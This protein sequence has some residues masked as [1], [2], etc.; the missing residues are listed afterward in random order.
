M[1]C[2][3]RGVLA[4]STLW[5]VGVSAG[6]IL[7][8][9]L[10]SLAIQPSGPA[11]AAGG[12]AQIDR[13]SFEQGL[14]R[15]RRL[16]R[17]Q[18]WKL[19]RD[20]W[21]ELARAHSGAEYARPELRE[22][23]LELQRASFWTTAVTPALRTLLSG[24]LLDHDPS[25]GTLRIRYTLESMGDFGRV[26]GSTAYVHPAHF[27]GPWTI[28][29]SGTAAEIR[30]VTLLC[31][32]GDSGVG[33]KFGIREPQETTYYAHALFAYEKQVNRELDS[34]DPKPRASSATTVKAQV[35]VGGASVRAQYDGVDV[36]EAPHA[37]SDFGQVIVI[38]PD[39]YGSLT[40][41]GEVD[42][43]WIDGLMDRAV[44]DQRRAFDAQWKD[45][46][47]FAAWG[48]EAATESADLSLSALLS[49]VKF[50]LPV[51]KAQDERVVALAAKTRAGRAD[52]L[53][54]LLEI[55]PP[56]ESSLPAESITYLRFCASLALG[57][58]QAALEQLEQLSPRAGHEREAKILRAIL[59]GRGGR[60]AES[61]AELEVLAK[62]H[63]RLAPLHGHLVESLLR[64][65]LRPEARA[66]MGRARAAMPASAELAK[67]EKQLVKAEMGPTWKTVFEI[68]GR[69][70]TVRSEVSAALC[71]D[72]LRVLD[73]AMERCTFE[74]GPLPTDKRERGVVYLF[75]GKA[76]YGDYV[77][78][79]ADGS[80]ENTRGIYSLLLKQ[81]VA[82]NQP[83]AAQLWDTLRHECVHRYLDLCVGDVPRWFGEGLAETLAAS[84]QADEAW[85]PGSLRSGWIEQ[86]KGGPQSVP[87][88][89]AFAYQDESEFRA[90]I[91]RSYAFAWAWMHYLRFRNSETRAL[92]AALWAALRD[93][94]DHSVAM[95]RALRGRNVEAL[96]RDFRAFFEELRRD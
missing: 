96:D 69:H 39:S 44:V 55:E 12:S 49:A 64:Q 47:E 63:P 38:A 50:E 10:S 52:A 35:S 92:F 59:L 67:L 31:S 77:A 93:G 75:A 72:A 82:W 16:S 48:D 21:L 51:N 30:G 7:A 4:R 58:H 88:L 95:D 90:Q 29:F 53:A 32:E 6:L 37:R 74:F 24:E 54:T 46:P 42:S 85:K 86:F 80:L 27:R 34:F 45:P 41:S 56:R 11:Q 73:R 13:A 79:I 15:A 17:A 2:S 28:E 18:K 84:A 91:E 25:A 33:V 14:D 8:L 5:R 71:R 94:A 1:K 81:V 9:S 43:G 22:V 68:E 76:G 66:V 70:F 83:D 36:L 3:G 78:G 60:P 89:I 57:R 23:R 65:G 87:G 61:A 40:I 20:A 26:P 19:S 62:A